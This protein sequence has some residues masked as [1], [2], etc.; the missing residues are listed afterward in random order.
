MFRTVNL[1]LRKQYGALLMYTIG[2]ILTQCD[3]HYAVRLGVRTA[4]TPQPCRSLRASASRAHICWDVAEVD[5]SAD[6]VDHPV[7]L[8]DPLA[9]LE[10]CP[11]PFMEDDA[12]PVPNNV[13]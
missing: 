9:R 13:V 3:P 8:A 5:R 10:E 6:A 7:Q 1:S 2:R 12:T 11:G 4:H